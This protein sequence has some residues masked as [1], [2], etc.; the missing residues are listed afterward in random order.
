MK[1]I[2]A[3]L[4]L[5][6]GLYPSL[7][8]Q[9]TSLKLDELMSAYAQ[10]REF[11]GT[12]LVAQHGKI[13]LEKGYGFQNIEKKLNNTK[14]TLYPIASVTKTITATLILKL[15]EMKQLSLKDKLSKYYPDYPMGDSIN[16]EH[17]L[18]HT[19]GIYNYTND[20]DFMF[21]QASNHASEQKMLSLFK[22]K[23]LDF[24]PGKGWSYSNSG[25]SLLGFI[26]EKVTGMP[27]YSAVRKYLF[28]TAGMT[29][30]G[31]NFVA[32]PDEKKAIG[33]YSDYGKD[34]NKQ[35]PLYDSSVVYS[36]GAVYSSAHDLYKWHQALQHNKI[37]TEQAATKAYTP[38]KQ[39]YGYGWIV[40]SVFN[41]RVVSHSGGIPG[42][43][44]N[45]A[46]VVEDDVCI[47]LLNNTETPGMSIITRSILAVLYNQPYTLPKG[48][49]AVK[50]ST[51]VLAQYT[52]AFE[53]EKQK[54]VI[55]FKIENNFLIAY[56]VNGPRSVL[57]ASD[58]T[59]FFDIEQEAV[60]ISFA[61]DETGK[62]NKII[63]DIGG[64][65]KTAHRI[66]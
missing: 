11:N 8:A 28:A 49:Q 21:N 29:N 19:A 13:L 4:C 54:L 1:K 6:I 58:E 20:N 22:N 65:I 26:V 45:F 44:S 5:L 33:Y 60:E 3:T 18:S 52:G 53:V 66:R 43:R 25:Y 27:Y 2:L 39:N 17:L 30:S 23:P 15:A 7:M 59:H 24:A 14:A 64:N 63:L 56:P 32:L 36:A 48:K 10:N 12:V 51:E 9:T 38:V 16:I 37:I 62:F 31:F 55:D 61:K 57:A 47:I 40:D 34:Y 41:N 42:Y 46:R 35:A 50:L